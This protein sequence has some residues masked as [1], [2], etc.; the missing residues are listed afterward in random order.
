VAF[1]AERMVNLLVLGREGRWLRVQH[2][3][4]TGWVHESLVWGPS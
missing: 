4:G 3:I 2:E 1:T